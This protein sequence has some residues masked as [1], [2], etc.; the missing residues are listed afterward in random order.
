MMLN[1]S[2]LAYLAIGI[3]LLFLAFHNIATKIFAKPDRFQIQI[4]SASPSQQDE[5]DSNQ[6]RPADDQDNQK[7]SPYEERAIIEA[8]LEAQNL[9]KWCREFERQ[10]LGRYF[11]QKFNQYEYA[12]QLKES[13]NVEGRRQRLVNE[14]L[15]QRARQM[16]PLIQQSI[17][18]QGYQNRMFA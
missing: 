15:S 10:E 18:T 14:I 6:S 1:Q 7:L 5:N 2:S 13:V 16:N 4:T 9:D 12:R 8:K 17:A 3:V 11:K